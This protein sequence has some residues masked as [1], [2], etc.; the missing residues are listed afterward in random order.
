MPD[1]KALI[2]DVDGTLAET[3][4]LHRAAFNRAFADAGLAVEWDRARYRELL[5]TTGG[6]RRIL[7]HF[8]ET[9][10]PPDEALAE[11]LH[12]S[13]NTHYAEAVGQGIALRAGVAD[14]MQRASQAGLRLAIA[15]TTSRANLAALLAGAGLP[16]FEVIVAGE[17][18]STLKPHP[19]VYL[20]ALEGLRLAPGA[21]LAFEDSANGL[22]SA[23]AAGLRTIVTPSHYSAGEDFSAAAAVL[24]DLT[25]FDWER[26]A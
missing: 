26:W 22:K 18:V 24:R 2:F 6:K 20:R 11:Q 23:N 14:V 15:T 8:A 25:D 12:R 21:T 17:D 16:A 3:E 13:K 5:G 9:A 1:L 4:E 7:R 19:E 10:M